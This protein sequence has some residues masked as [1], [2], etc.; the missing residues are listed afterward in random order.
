MG[1]RI[2]VTPE[3]M[4]KAS[5][6]LKTISETYTEIYKKLFQEVGTMG[7]AW[8]GEDNIAFVNQINGF[9]EELKQMADKIM[10]ASTTLKQQKDNY[11]T[12]Q[13]N[14]VTEVKKLAN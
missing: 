7:E 8:E 6:S 3:E 1:K 12:T 5:N 10:L 9:C 4:E 11:V 14:L 13:Q 2:R